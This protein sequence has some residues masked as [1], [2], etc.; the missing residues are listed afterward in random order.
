MTSVAK[1]EQVL[2]SPSATGERL[3]LSGRNSSARASWKRLGGWWVGGGPCTKPGEAGAHRPFGILGTAGAL[4]T[5]GAGEL[6]GH[7]L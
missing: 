5:E 3:C 2:L 1:V 4:P 7:A 6:R